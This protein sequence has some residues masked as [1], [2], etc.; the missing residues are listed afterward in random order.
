ML[1]NRITI[2]EK[3][4][5]AAREEFF[6]LTERKSQ[7]EERNQRLKDSRDIN[8]KKA[9][10]DLRQCKLGARMQPPCERDEVIVM[11][12]T[13]W[14]L[15]QE[16]EDEIVKIKKEIK[17]FD[18]D[19]HLQKRELKKWTDYRD[20]GRAKM[21]AHIQLLKEEITSMKDNFEVVKTSLKDNLV[22]SMDDIDKNAD[23]TIKRKQEIAADV[24][25]LSFNLIFYLSICWWII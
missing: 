3:E 18:K 11:M 14:L 9:M 22:Q 17:V 4:L 6:K 15:K 13:L 25:F 21:E 1:L 24:K 2:E 23:E 10:D 5:E 8:F 19:I 7:L 16:H 12:K 20:Q